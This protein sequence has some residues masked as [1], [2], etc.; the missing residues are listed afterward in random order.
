MSSKNIYFFVGML[1]SLLL[2]IL[3]SYRKAF[4]TF[5]ATK[6]SRRKTHG[7]MNFLIFVVHQCSI[8]TFNIFYFS[9]RLTCWFAWQEDP[10]QRYSRCSLF[11]EL[12]CNL[13]EKEEGRA[14]W[15]AGTAPTHQSIDLEGRRRRRGR[16]SSASR[17]VL[18]ASATPSTTT[19]PKL[20]TPL[21]RRTDVTRPWRKLTAQF[22]TLL[23]HWAEKMGKSPALQQRSRDKLSNKSR[24]RRL[25]NMRN[26]SYQKR[27]Q[28]SW[29]KYWNKSL[30]TQPIPKN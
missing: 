14:I 10:V 9:C 26:I 25:G 13:I 27:K 7:D 2:G 24:Y 19:L 20:A 4:V 23:R 15:L 16:Q 17:I 29:Y 6:I 8:L 28:I 21:L 18:P 5:I 12:S 11:F 1:L 22:A 30:L 3:G